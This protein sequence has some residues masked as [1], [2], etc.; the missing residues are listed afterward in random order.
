MLNLQ[1][2][3]YFLFEIIAVD[4]SPNCWQSFDTPSCLSTGWGE[5]FSSTAKCFKS[6][7]DST[8]SW[9]LLLQIV[10]V[11]KRLLSN[12][13]CSYFLWNTHPLALKMKDILPLIIRKPGEVVWCKSEVKWLHHD[14]DKVRSWWMLWICLSVMFVGSGRGNGSGTGSANA[15]VDAYGCSEEAERGL[16]RSSPVCGWSYVPW[17][18]RTEGRH[19]R[20]VLFVCVCGEHEV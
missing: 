5:R 10:Q 3:F 19:G 15:L 8:T 1:F 7:T 20:I 2:V 11:S 17:R 6:D 4:C 14:F 9:M 12:W 16:E 13:K 18:D